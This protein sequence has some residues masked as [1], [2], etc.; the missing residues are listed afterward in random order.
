MRQVVADRARFAPMILDLAAQ[1]AGADTHPLSV[2]PSHT[3]LKLSP[4]NPDRRG[5]FRRKH[6]RHHLGRAPSTLSPP[7]SPRAPKSSRGAF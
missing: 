2:S 3:P 4:R 7:A 1:I 5:A 6:G